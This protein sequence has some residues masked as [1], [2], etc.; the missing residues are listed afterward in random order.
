MLKASTIQERVLHRSLVLLGGL[1]RLSAYLVIPERD[2]M[3]WLGGFAAPPAGVY[4]RLCELVERSEGCTPT[5]SDL[6]A[7]A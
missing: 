2:L 7:G 4:S 5:G 3:D 1:P 6:T